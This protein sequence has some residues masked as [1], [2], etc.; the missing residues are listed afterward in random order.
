M[1]LEE[2]IVSFLEMGMGDRALAAYINACNDPRVQAIQSLEKIALDKNS[3]L[4][5]IN[6]AVK[7]IVEQIT[8]GGV[9]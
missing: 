7:G 9:A 4:S 1:T 6:V 8:E 3:P 2:Q 5:A